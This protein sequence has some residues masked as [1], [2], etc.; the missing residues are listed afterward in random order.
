MKWYH[1]LDNNDFYKDARVF[2]LNEILFSIL[3]ASPPFGLSEK[4][5]LSTSF[6]VM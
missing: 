2:S 3:T 1:R 4:E 6:S 5:S